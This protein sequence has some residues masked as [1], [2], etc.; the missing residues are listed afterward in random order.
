MERID[1][2]RDL[3][4]LNEGQV[5]GL[6]ANPREWTWDDVQRLVASL[7]ETPEF[8]E[9]NRLK[10][11]PYK[12]RYVVLGGNMRCVALRELGYDKMP[13]VVVPEGWEIGKL[14]RLVIKDNANWGEWDDG[15]LDAEWSEFDFQAL[16]IR[17]LEEMRAQEEKTVE[18]EHLAELSIVC[19]PDEF[20]RILDGLRKI[21][22]DRHRAVLKL[23]GYGA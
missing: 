1:I 4:D 18:K 7:K 22:E 15:L 19:S 23:F 8:L 9:R 12:G 17:P 20:I 16:N 3:I 11:Y 5:P 10:V 2:D 21:D 6:P 13:C 14:R